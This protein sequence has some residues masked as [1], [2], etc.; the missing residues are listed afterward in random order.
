MKVQLV[1][2]D[3]TERALVSSILNESG[4][5]TSVESRHSYSGKEKL[6]TYKVLI[7]HNAKEDAR[8]ET[9]ES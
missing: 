9:N 3:K 5:T 8:E 6:E 2:K 1:I 7:V 4:Y